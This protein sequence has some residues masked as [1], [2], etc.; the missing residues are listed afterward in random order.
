M[1]KISL[2]ELYEMNFEIKN[3]FA[4]RQ[5]GVKGAVFEMNYP[6]P[7]NG[8]IYLKNCENIYIN[9]E[10]EEFTAKKDSVVWLPEQSKYKCCSIAAGNTDKDAYLIQFNMEA[11]GERIIIADSPFL[12][13]AADNY[14][15][16]SKMKEITELTESALQSPAAIKGAVFNLIACLCREDSG[17]FDK[18]YRCISKGIEYLEKNPTSKTSIE[19][20]AKMCNVSSG[21][22][23]RLFKE[24]S[25][26]SPVD[27]RLN[28]QIDIAKNMLMGEYMPLSYICEMLEIDNVPYFCKLFLKRTGM[29]PTEYREN[30]IL[31][32]L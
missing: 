26:K 18:K 14:A 21:T 7:Q 15:V 12:V 23:R 10:K 8:I 3:I 25:G 30:K 28:K 32:S 27:F 2:R 11:E 4:I 31:N 6:R 22:F 9:K 13:N 17:D 20:I 16:L 24:Y 1:K 19:D 5:I 29:T